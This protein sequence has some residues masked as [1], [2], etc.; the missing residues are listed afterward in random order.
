MYYLRSAIQYIGLLNSSENFYNVYETLSK[1]ND[2]FIENSHRKLMPLAN[3]LYNFG[4]VGGGVEKGVL[5]KR[6]LS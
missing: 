3:T 5:N 4:L 1:K 6:A 2:D